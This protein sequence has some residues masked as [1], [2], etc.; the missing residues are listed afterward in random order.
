MLKVSVG[1]AIWCC[2]MLLTGICAYG[3]YKT[4]KGKTKEGQRKALLICGLVI[5][6]LYF[7]QRFFMFRDPI[8]FETYGSEPKDILINLLPLHLCYSGLL[9]TMVGLYKDYEPLMAFGFHVGLLGAVLAMVSPDGY[10]DQQSLLH[11]PT[12]FFYV[13]H[14]LLAAMYACIGLL[15][16]FRRGR[17]AEARSL[18]ILIMM[19][20]VLHGINTLGARIGLDGMN[21]CYT[22]TPGGSGILELLWSWVPV[23]WLYVVL[24]GSLFYWV[25]VMALEG[26]R[27]LWIMRQGKKIAV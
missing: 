3:I 16:M 5:Y 6:G 8:F 24:P 27:R 17:K 18:L 15:G 12:F 1:N 19:T 9:L 21:Y 13:T 10:Y 25:W 11:L 2:I 26:I 23:Q 14:G 7:V 20:L 22:V 4:Q